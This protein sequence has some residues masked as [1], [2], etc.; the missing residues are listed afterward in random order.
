MRMGIHR[1]TLAA[2]LAGADDVWLY[3]PPDLGWDA[4]AVVAGLGGRGHAE[5]SLDG[6]LAG[7]AASLRGGDQVLVMSNGGFGG[8][9]RRLLDAL[10]ARG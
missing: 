2:S 4:S 3:A 10:R 6:L 9:H 5:A 1:D 7:L 8:L